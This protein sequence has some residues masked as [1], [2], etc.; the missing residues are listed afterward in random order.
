MQVRVGSW[1]LGFLYATLVIGCGRTEIR[2]RHIFQS[3]G[4]DGKIAYY[5]LE[6][7]GD[8]QLAKIHYR[9]GLYDAEALDA[10]FG[11]TNKDDTSTIDGILERRRREA[12]EKLSSLYYRTLEESDSSEPEIRKIRARFLEAMRSAYLLA[13]EAQFEEDADNESLNQSVPARRKYA[14]I[15]SSIASE[16][17]E[18]I[19]NVAE[20]RETGEQVMAAIA[21]LRRE[22]FLEAR[23]KSDVLILQ[24]ERARAIRARAEALRPPADNAPVADK[25]RF[26]DEVGRLL[27]DLE[28]LRSE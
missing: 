24:R 12:V 27:Q 8:A 22:S 2:E 6:V 19:A 18:A 16:V 4:P 21:A 9:A 26:T 7:R 28:S 5:L 23:V 11:V 3:V 20:E 17:E 13:E 10:L 14:I 1:A 15:F 25:N